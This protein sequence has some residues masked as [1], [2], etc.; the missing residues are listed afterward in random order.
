MPDIFHWSK[1][2]YLHLQVKPVELMMLDE[3]AIMLIDCRLANQV[4]KIDLKEKRYVRFDKE[5]IKY[6]VNMVL[7]KLT[8]SDKDAI[9]QALLEEN[10]IVRQQRK[11][12][13][14]T[15]KESE[16][17]NKMQ[18]SAQTPLAMSSEDEFSSWNL[19]TKP[20]NYE[21]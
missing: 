1:I 16:S 12:E 13:Q 11:A 3:G 5:Y 14:E 19:E 21:K 4:Q 18:L 20:D 15:P 6:R 7:E 9:L 2:H 8:L 17:D 10:E